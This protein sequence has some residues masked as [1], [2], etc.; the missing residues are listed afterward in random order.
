MTYNSNIPQPSDL[1]SV[2]QVDLLNNFSSLDTQFGVDHTALTAGSDNG[3][4]KKSTYI[5]Q[6]ADPA[7]A[8]NETALYSKQSALTS[9]T[10]LF[11][12]REGSG[13]I[14]EVSNKLGAA[15]GWSY[16]LSGL[17]LKWGTATNSPSVGAATITIPSGGAVPA[18][19]S[20]FQIFLTIDDSSGTPNTFVYL[21]GLPSPNSFSVYGVQR[22]TTTPQT[23]T[24]RYLAIGV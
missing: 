19:T 10:Q 23:V 13:T 3:K 6:A 7:T 12:R 14:S 15:T 17:L 22:T 5:E 20:L 8:A 4:H 2:S 18:F 24:F 16:T 9:D 1:I 11:L 21:T